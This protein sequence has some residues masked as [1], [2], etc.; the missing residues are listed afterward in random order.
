MNQELLLIRNQIKHSS[1]ALGKET[2]SDKKTMVSSHF[3]ADFNR[4]LALCKTLLPNIDI[5]RWPTELATPVAAMG[6]SLSTAT[7]AEVRAYYAQLVAI[8]DQNLKDFSKPSLRF[9]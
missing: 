9:L 7:V 3:A 2:A 8:C 6:P 5:N 4:L 1:D